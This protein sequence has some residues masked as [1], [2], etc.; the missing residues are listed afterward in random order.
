[1]PDAPVDENDIRDC[2]ALRT[3]NAALG[4][5]PQ[6]MPMPWTDGPNAGFTSPGIKP[7]LPIPGWASRV[8]VAEQEVEPDSTLRMVRSLI[9]YRQTNDALLHG[10]LA[11]LSDDDDVVLLLRESP[12]ETLL[13]AISLTERRQTVAL[14]D[15]QWTT[16][17]A[18][19][20]HLIGR[21][22]TRTAEVDGLEA[23]ILRRTEP[24]PQTG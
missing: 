12:R 7:W 5:D 2:A 3:H 22:F 20:A 8:S 14:L 11:V 23:L 15:G 19:S 17:W 1:M 21:T 24:A 4:R 13:V 9:R 16:D 18:T 10:T 6:R